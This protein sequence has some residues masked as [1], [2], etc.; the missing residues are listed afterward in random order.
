MKESLKDIE[1]SLESTPCAILFPA[2]IG[3]GLTS[4]VLMQ[5]LIEQHNAVVRKFYSKAF[6]DT[7]FD[8][9]PFVSCHE[10]VH[11]SVLIAVDSQDLHLALVANSE[12]NFG[13]GE[14][15]GKVEWILHEEALEHQIIEK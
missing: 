11:P 6:P 13:V 8:D 2:S 10:I 3:L 12:Y 4:T 1:L 7:K 5:L 14:A 9:I 15:A